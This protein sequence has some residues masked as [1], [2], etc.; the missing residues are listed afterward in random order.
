MIAY[1]KSRI[2]DF[3]WLQLNLETLPWVRDWEIWEAQRWRAQNH[4]PPFGFTVDAGQVNT[5]CFPPSPPVMS[6]CCMVHEDSVSEIAPRWGSD[7][8]S[9]ICTQ[10]ADAIS[11]NIESKLLK[12]LADEEA[13]FRKTMQYM[14][15][16]SGYGEEHSE[17]IGEEEEA[18][19]DMDWVI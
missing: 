4:I 2:L 13:D 16:A 14:V 1:Y 18:I 12:E 19:G 7:E 6:S 10:E 15:D 9:G 5:G 11:D 3:L 17:D 8:E